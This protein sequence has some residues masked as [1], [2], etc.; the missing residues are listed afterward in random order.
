MRAP[1]TIAAIA[2]WLI[3]AGLFSRNRPRRTAGWF[4]L[5]TD[6][7][8]L[9]NRALPRCPAAAGATGR[10]DADARRIRDFQLNGD[11][12]TGRAVHR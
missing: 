2:G 5:S 4:F 11:S 12:I 7:R 8:A 6:T 1:V 10:G 9:R 3:A